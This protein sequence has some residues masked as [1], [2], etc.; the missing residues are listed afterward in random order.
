MKALPRRGRVTPALLLAI[1]LVGASACSSG[2]GTRGGAAPGIPATSAS[3]TLVVL[4]DAATAP[5]TDTIPVGESWPQR[6]FRAALTRDTVLV[7][8]APQVASARLAS[9]L[10]IPIA[11]RLHPAVIAVLVGFLDVVEQRPID[12][13]RTT[14]ERLMADIHTTGAH[15]VLVATLPDEM[16]GVAP[17]N[18]VITQAVHAAGAVLVDLAPL[19]THFVRDP[20][21]ITPVPD[22]ASQAAI[23]AAFTAAYRAAV[24]T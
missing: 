20:E 7:N 17:Y 5:I 8:L 14:F 3:P 18:A 4:G 15:T 16:R 21:P 9:Q 1:S 12:D 13:F 23:A 22:R 2:S 10:E 19:T 11:A 24:P 6:F